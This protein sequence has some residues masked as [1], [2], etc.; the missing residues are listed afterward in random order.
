MHR[1]GGQET[2]ELKTNMSIYVCMYIYISPVILRADPGKGYTCG[3]RMCHTT[4]KSQIMKSREL[5]PDG[6]RGGTVTLSRQ[7][8]RWIWAQ[9]R[10]SG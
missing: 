7:Q 6:L 4:D 5:T 3:H 1:D 9:A 2:E 10:I 8:R